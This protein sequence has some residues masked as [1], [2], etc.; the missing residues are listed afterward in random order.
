MIPGF[1]EHY[2]RYRLLA[3]I[4]RLKTYPPG[5]TITIAKAAH[6]LGVS[7][8]AMRVLINRYAPN[9][10]GD[11]AKITAATLLAVLRQAYP[12]RGRGN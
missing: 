6:L 10:A 3:S 8:S 7:E 4:D 11:E 5:S 12:P 9:S 2:R 1:G